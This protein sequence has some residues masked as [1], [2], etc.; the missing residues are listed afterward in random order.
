[1]L[2][3]LGLLKER[4]FLPLFITQFLGAF[5]DNFFKTAMVLFAT[6]QI[7]NDAAVESNFNALATGLSLL[8]FFLLSA[9][10][11]QLADTVDKA[12]I[13]RLVKTAEILIMIG[14]AAG[15]MIAAAGHHA[16]GMGMMLGAV[17]CLGIHST[18]FGPI[19]YA[20]LPQHLDRDH[21]LAGTGLIEAGTYLAILMGTVLAGWLSV[22]GSAIGVLIVAAIGWVAGRQVPP[23]PREGPPLAL[24]YNPFTASWRLIG[25]TMHIPRLFLAICSISF[26]WT[27]G[28]VLIIIFPPLVKNILTA[29]ERVASLVIAIFSVGI[30]IGSVVINTML[31]GRISAR[32]APASVIAMGGFVVLFSLLVRTWTPLPDGQFY[33]VLA[34]IAEPHAIAITLSLVGVAITGGMFVVPLY[35]FL[36]TTVTKDQTARTVAAN[37]VVN[38]GAMVIGSCAVL[39][40]TAAGVTPE[41][42]LLLVAAMCL[43]AAWLAQKLHLACD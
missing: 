6:Y 18:F 20:I 36:T 15:L 25:A 29:D 40:L 22:E 11:G 28:A 33:G 9:L 21:V 2:S 26:F 14:G 31:R 12:K 24:N 35:A 7:F 34:F 30:A 37:N 5:N 13:I 38:S 17:L 10:S 27:I 42:M 8:P 39:A 19:K 4:R 23:A 1:M 43:V 3:A 32:F 16:I 41:N